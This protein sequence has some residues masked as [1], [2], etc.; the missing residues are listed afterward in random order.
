MAKGNDGN[1]LQH[2]VEVAVAVNL[3]CKYAN[4]RLHL[5]LAHGMA[6][7]EACGPLPHGQ[8]RALLYRS[9]HAAQGSP[10]S[11]EPLI[12]AAYRATKAS[13]AHYPNTAE[14]L[15]AVIGEDR[16]TGG[17][18]EVDTAKWLQLEQGWSRSGIRPVNSSWRKQVSLGGALAYPA[19]ALFV[20]ATKPDV[21]RRFWAFV[22][23]LA[24]RTNTIVSS[25]WLTHQGGNRNLAALLCSGFVLPAQWLPPGLN[26]G[27]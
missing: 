17:I 7:F 4:G 18:T 14:L 10:D 8:T 1:Y 2:S 15:R 22:D 13:L 24:E 6:P 9:L 20:Y 3:A 27:R 25:C 11:S 12:V 26:A 23:E 5:A 19:A 21:Q 16:L